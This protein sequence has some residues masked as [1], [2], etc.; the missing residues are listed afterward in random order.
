VATFNIDPVPETKDWTIQWKNNL[1]KLVDKLR[2]WATNIE[3]ET[4]TISD[5]LVLE[6]DGI[7]EG[8]LDIEDD[9]SAQ[10]AAFSGEVT[11]GEDLN[12]GG[13][14]DAENSPVLFGPITA[15]GT[16]ISFVGIPSWARKINVIHSGLSLSGTD[17]ILI[18]M[19]PASGLE[20]TG[21]IS[22]T[23]NASNGG[24]FAIDTATDGFIIRHGVAADG[25]YGTYELLLADPITNLWVGEGSHYRA[26]TARIGGSSGSKAFSGIVWLLS[27]VPT[28]ANTFDGGTVS[29]R[30]E[31]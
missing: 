19:G 13:L 27:L 26:G 6:G 3:S 29:V 20:T 18:R 22:A 12:V 28:G 15:S 8:S 4:V 16:S 9:I 30:C 2:S 25:L 21:Y 10:D 5:T 24:A 17:N 11:I 14:L 31:Y 1:S 7:I 23:G